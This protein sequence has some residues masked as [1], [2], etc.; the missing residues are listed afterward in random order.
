MPKKQL[1]AVKKG[2]AKKSI[3]LIEQVND[4]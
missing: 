1:G 3:G 4:I 2:V